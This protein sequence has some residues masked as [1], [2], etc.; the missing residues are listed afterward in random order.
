MESD[1]YIERFSRTSTATYLGYIKYE[2]GLVEDG[3]LAASKAAQA[4]VG[5]DRALRHFLVGHEP[6][7]GGAE[8]EFPVRVRRSSWEALLPDSPGL[9]IKAGLGLVASAYLVGAARKAGANDIGEKGLVDL[10]RISLQSVQWF[11]RF[12]KHLGEIP[13]GA[14]DGVKVDLENQMVGIPNEDGEIFWIPKFHYDLLRASP[15]SLL[16]DLVSVVEEDRELVVGT[17]DQGS[18][19]EVRAGHADRAIFVKDEEEELFPELKHGDRVE[20][21]GEVT[22]GN[23][24]TNKIGFKYK[25]HILTCAPKT[26]RITRFK[27]VM[28]SKARIAGVISRETSEG[29]LWALR[30]K[31]IFTNLVRLG[32]NTRQQDLF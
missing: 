18:V 7:L 5:L 4:L 9:W 15:P 16:S 24:E 14:A 2:G 30:P 8:F 11:I 26:G 21:D 12:G 31:I 25:G 22:R 17:I 28:F 32:P 29:E 1:L 13:R 10:V 23:G 20:L 27:S 19:A 3:Y 6:K